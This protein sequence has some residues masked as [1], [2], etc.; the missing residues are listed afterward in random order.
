MDHHRKAQI[1]QTVHGREKYPGGISPADPEGGG[2]VDGLKA[3]L[4]PD[5]FTGKLLL[6][7]A[8][9]RKDPLPQTV[10]AGS[11]G[12]AG[13]FRAGQGFPK[14]AVQP[15]RVPV[16][17]GVG[18]EIGD[19]PGALGR[20]SLFFGGAVRP[21]FLQPALPLGQPG[22]EGIRTGNGKIP[23]AAGGAEGAAAG[24]RCTVPVGA[25]AADIQGHLIQFVPVN[26]FAPGVQ[27]IPGLLVPVLP[28]GRPHVSGCSF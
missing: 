5:K 15:V 8:E 19:E 17:V 3:Q 28:D 26:I 22:P 20:H 9:A 18:L 21:F 1:V 16:G 11:D 14:K 13:R 2:I 24:S 6:K 23:A 25:A 27:G 12:N 10:R 7:P 4:D